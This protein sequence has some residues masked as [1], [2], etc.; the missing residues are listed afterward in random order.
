MDVKTALQS[1]LRK[2]IPDARVFADLQLDA[3]RNGGERADLCILH[4]S[5]VYLVLIEDLDG[6]L[7]G[8]EQTGQ[9][10]LKKPDGTVSYLEDP[11]RK[12]LR[13]EELLE[14]KV[15]GI[16]SFLHPVI[17]YGENTWVVEKQISSPVLFSGS[18]YF[19]SHLMLA[20]QQ[21]EVLSAAQRDIFAKQLTMLQMLSRR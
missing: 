15:R 13:H 5:G 4:R 9:W 3:R 21:E 2:K 8:S 14:K 19:L 16:G 1:G 17:V 18:D 11:V 7:Y 10:K 12:S 6:M 20:A